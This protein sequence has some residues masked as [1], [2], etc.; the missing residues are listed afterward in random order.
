MVYRLNITSKAHQC[1]AD[2]AEYLYNSVGS[3]GNPG[4]A[5]KFLNE[6]EVALDIL[7]KQAESYAVC[8]EGELRLNGYRRIR[9]KTLRYKIFYRVEENVVMIDLITHDSQDYT[10][11][12]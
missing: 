4:A 9:F 6:Y 1:V 5:A 8:E 2:I 10:K 7:S 11:L 3:F 12:L